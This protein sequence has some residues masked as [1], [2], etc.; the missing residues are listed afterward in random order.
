VTEVRPASGSSEVD[1]ALELRRRVFVDEQGVTLAADQ[2]GRD[3]E[4][5]HIVAYAEGRLVGT[6]RL[7]FDDG[8]ARLGRMAVERDQRG[9]GIGAA[10]LAEAE[11]EARAAGATKIRLHAQTDARSLYE[12]SGFGV[13]G[14][15]FLEEGIPHVTMEKP[16][17]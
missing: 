3:P 5:L 6:C 1:E 11:R 17:A 12:R 10:I 16:L 2:D 8:I 4:A 13:R 15:E 7:V 9:R 14:E